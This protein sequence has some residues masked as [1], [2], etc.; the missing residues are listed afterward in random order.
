[1]SKTEHELPYYPSRQSCQGLDCMVPSK[2]TLTLSGLE[3]VVLKT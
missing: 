3:S 1:M 2:I